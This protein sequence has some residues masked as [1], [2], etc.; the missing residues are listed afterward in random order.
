MLEIDLFS[1]AY[2]MQAGKEN[3]EIFHGN[4]LGKISWESVM[5]H[6]LGLMFCSFLQD[7][8]LCK[9][10]ISWLPQYWVASTR[11]HMCTY[12]TLSSIEWNDSYSRRLHLGLLVVFSTEF[13]VPSCEWRISIDSGGFHSGHSFC[14]HGIPLKRGKGRNTLPYSPAAMGCDFS[15]PDSFQP[16]AFIISISLTPF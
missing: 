4:F 8:F 13:P 7:L 2:T 10:S 15:I 12:P 3:E 11:Q 16:L 5:F 6:P 14:S 1:S 9:K